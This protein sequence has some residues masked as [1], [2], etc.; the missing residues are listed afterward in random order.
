LGLKHQQP[1]FDK[2]K[3]A[4]V[5]HGFVKASFPPRVKIIDKN[6]KNEKTSLFYDLSGANDF[7]FVAL[8]KKLLRWEK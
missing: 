8:G 6:L 2:V 7:S 4:S 3:S 1:P 5:A